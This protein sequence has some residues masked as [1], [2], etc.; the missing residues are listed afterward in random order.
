[1]EPARPQGAAL[2][3]LFLTNGLVVS[4]ALV[5]YGPG[6]QDDGAVTSSLM[7]AAAR[8]SAAMP[9][10]SMTSCSQAAATFLGS[11]DLAATHRTAPRL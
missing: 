11:T 9:Q 3:K 5:V 2:A 1:M 10:S 8:S 4:V 6:K 7:R